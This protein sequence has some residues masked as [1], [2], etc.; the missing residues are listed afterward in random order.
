[1]RKQAIAFCAAASSRPVLMIYGGDLT[2]MLMKFRQTTVV[3]G[4]RIVR[5]GGRACEWCIHRCYFMWQDDHDVLRVRT[6]FEAPVLMASK[7]TWHTYA[8]AERLAPLLQSWH[9][10]GVSISWYVFDRGARAPM[11]RLLRRRHAMALRK[12]ENPLEH[13]M[14]DV[15]DWVVDSACADHDVQ[16]GL[17]KGCS[18]G[19]DK[20]KELTKNIFKGVRS[21]RDTYDKLMET[22]PAWVRSLEIDNEKYD[23][24][25]V[26]SF[27]LFLGAKCSTAE[28]LAAI[29]LRWERGAL[30][31]HVSVMKLDDPLGHV[32]SLILASYRIRSFSDSRFLSL[33]RTCQGLASAWSV[34]LHEHMTF[35][36]ASPEC[37]EYYTHCYD[38]LANDER[39]FVCKAAVVSHTTDDLHRLLLIDDRI[40]RDP[41]R[42]IDSLMKQ[43]HRVNFEAPLLLYERLA[44]HVPGVNA[45]VLESVILRGCYCAGSYIDRRLFSIA[46]KPVFQM[47][48]GNVV[49]KVAKLGSSTTPKPKDLILQ[50][51]QTLLR[52]GT[53]QVLVVQAFELLGQAPWSIMKYEQMHGSGATQH[54]QHREYGPAT[55]ASKAVVHMMLPLVRAAQPVDPGAVQARRLEALEA[56]RPERSGA[57][58]LFLRDAVRRRMDTLGS[59]ATSRERFLAAQEVVRSSASSFRQLPLD[60]RRV[61][62]QDAM[63][64]KK[65]KRKELDQKIAVAEE[66]LLA[67]R[68]RSAELEAAS[69]TLRAGLAGWSETDLKEL[70]AMMSEKN[71]SRQTIAQECEKQLHSPPIPTYET[72]CKMLDCDDD[73]PAE[74]HI[75]CPAWIAQVCKHRELF[76]DVALVYGALPDAPAFVLGYGSKSPFWAV[77][78]KLLLV[79]DDDADKFETVCEF[80]WTRVGHAFIG[81]VD[82]SEWF[83]EDHE[84]LEDAPPFVIPKLHFESK[85]YVWSDE[86]QQ[87]YADFVEGLPAPVVAAKKA[88]ASEVDETLAEKH[89]WIRRVLAKTSEEQLARRAEVLDVAADEAEAADIAGVAEVLAE[90]RMELADFGDDP[91]PDF[92]LEPRGGAFT[93]KVHGMAI[94]S[95]RGR[96]QAGLPT[97]WMQM[98]WRH[99]AR[100]V[101]CSIEKFGA[102]MC[103]AFCRLW[104]LMMQTWFDQFIDSVVGSAIIYSVI[105][106]PS[107]LSPEIRLDVEALGE[108]HPTKVRFAIFLHLRP[109]EVQLILKTC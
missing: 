19:H 69:S 109:R 89:P 1:M 85:Y 64:E 91:H 12:I 40:A 72:R 58:G 10:T 108:E 21:V 76:A 66:A 101:T 5:V 52:L 68:R 92:V 78:T 27:W 53:P 105:D 55:L 22:L 84:L 48:S 25:A 100:S 67:K 11:V 99:G 51:A 98:H 33:G 36:R 90:A 86:A 95:Y 87:T 107:L 102:R 42:F 82:C 13:T 96:A 44:T 2:P 50:K 73:M 60:L 74:D 4:S 97:E 75:T 9:P 46:R 8:C 29:N 79:S 43:I 94:D 20:M 15:C 71:F 35:V 59:N 14:A 7:K 41:S 93:K 106:V 49:E 26:L 104:C 32:G 56:R 83:Y 88:R 34:G 6:A 31:C 65:L 23:E 57:S 77:F 30:R 3:A 54:R 38:L 28:A 103:I 39:L 47:C 70:D 63:V 62:E 16:N 37:G 24:D 80:P 45:V 17:C 61:F 18:L 81:S